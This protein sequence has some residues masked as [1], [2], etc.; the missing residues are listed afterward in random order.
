VC[1]GGGVLVHQSSV[2][3]RIRICLSGF[4]GI[5]GERKLKN[6]KNI[7]GGGREQLGSCSRSAS[8]MVFQ[9]DVKALTS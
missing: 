7:G 5:V 8:L 2:L 6:E 1:A 4:H 3:A 9:V